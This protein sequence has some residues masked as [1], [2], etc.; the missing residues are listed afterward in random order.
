MTDEP[1]G[2]DS[3]FLDEVAAAERRHRDSRCRCG[4]K[5]RLVGADGP[6]LDLLVA[7][8][9]C[10]E[11]LDRAVFSGMESDALAEEV[12]RLLTRYRAIRTPPTPE[13]KR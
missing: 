12:L 7:G 11:G 8:W 13:V 4:T 1:R 5:A 9:R 2:P 3:V 10:A 6:D